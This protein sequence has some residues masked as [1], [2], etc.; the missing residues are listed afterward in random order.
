V[1]NPAP[2]LSNNH[3][4]NVNLVENTHEMKSL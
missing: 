4:T 2:E 3:V 1:D